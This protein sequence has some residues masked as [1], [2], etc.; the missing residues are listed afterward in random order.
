MRLR[1]S[2]LQSAIQL[3]PIRSYSAIKFAKRELYRRTLIAN[4]RNEAAHQKT[5]FE[6]EKQWGKNGNSRVITDQT[7]DRDQENPRI[8]ATAQDFNTKIRGRSRIKQLLIGIKKFEWRQ[9]C[10]D[11]SNDLL[12]GAC[13]AFALDLA[14]EGVALVDGEVF[15]VLRQPRLPLLVHKQHETNPIDMLSLTLSRR[16]LFVALYMIRKGENV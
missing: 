7:R 8:E 5:R 10:R 3:R 13:E 1:Q 11:G 12:I 15:V 4:P 6:H 2:L 16:R 9:R 14:L